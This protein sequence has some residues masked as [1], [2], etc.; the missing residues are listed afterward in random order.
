MASD[1]TE[2]I[3]CAMPHLSK[4]HKRIVEYIRSHP[5]NAAYMT[6]SKL[7]EVA[8][9]SESTVVRFATLLGF[10]G[11]P[12]LHRALQ[13]TLQ[14]QLTSVQRVRVANDRLPDDKLLDAVLERDAAQ[15]RSTLE[16][17][18]RNAFDAAVEA[19]LNAGKI[20]IIGMRSSYALA[21]FLE[22]HLNLIFPNVQ[23]VRNVGGSEIFEQMM[24]IG[25]GDTVVAISFP[26]YSTRIVKA[27]DFAGRSGAKVVSVTDSLSSPIAKNAYAT[28][29]AKSNMTS[30][31][32]SLV[33]PLSVINALI[34]AISKKKQAEISA[35]LDRL[36]RV[37]DEYQVYD[38]KNVNDGHGH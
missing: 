4:G 26:R 2:I 1:L 9:V 5:E 29:S 34:A 14:K 35:A 8:G 10:S 27:V 13:E 31:A 16:T 3:D 23:L 38:N 25:E 18:D 15:I 33:A 21:E 32:D 24:N 6:A 36:E 19:I 22:Y 7:G 12:E 17:I 30:F 28:L 20:Y 11:Y 37:W